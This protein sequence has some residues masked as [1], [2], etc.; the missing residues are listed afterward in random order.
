VRARD[1]AGA[2]GRRPGA[3]VTLARQVARNTAAQA[4]GKAAV[5]AVGAASIAVTTRYLGAAGYGGFAL[6]LAFVQMLGVLA[7]AGIVTVVVREISR[8]PRRTA[9]LVGNALA[10]RLVLGLAVV[11]LAGLLSLA[12][13]YAPEVREAI[14]IAGVPFMLGLASSS[15]ATVFQARLQMGRAAIADVAG[16]LAAFAALVAVVAADLGFLAVVAST[17]VGAAVTLA[18]T[19]ALVRGFVPVRLLTGR[20]REL[21]V[22]AVPLGITL[23]VNEIYFRADTFILSLFRPFEEVGLYTLAYRIFE[24]LAL[25]PAIVMTSIFP[26]LSRYVPEQRD[27][28]ARVIDATADLFVAIAVPVAAGGLVLA[29][30]L[31]RLAAGD[32]FAD[33]ATPL[34][35]LLC[36]AGAAWVSG[37]LGYALIADHRQREVL[38]LSLAA[39]AANLALNLALV[40][41]YGP[42]AAAAIALGC[43]AAILAGGWVLVRRH[44]GISP[45]MRLLWRALLAAAAMTALLLWLDDVTLALLIPAGAAVYAAV[46]AAVGGIDRRLLEAF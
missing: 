7:D 22:P 33:A 34:R 23:A 37:L 1:G 10:I 45:R 31:V 13:P 20:W 4:L 24:L 12:L 44:L 2:A 14:V 43:E 16:R 27:L 30:E 6:A 36:A 35:L 29:P 32:A 26:L 28:A 9:E 17:G 15:L 19:V 8:E 25:L 42:D 21:L 40:P 18:V 38:L 3:Q 5:L 41:S 39:L 11:A 46:L